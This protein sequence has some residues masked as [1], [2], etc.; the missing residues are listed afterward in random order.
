ML[1]PITDIVKDASKVITKIMKLNSKE[2]YKGTSDP[3]EKTFSY[4]SGLGYIS[5]LS[6]VSFV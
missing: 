1:E 6:P 5:V 2:S 4:N 3:N